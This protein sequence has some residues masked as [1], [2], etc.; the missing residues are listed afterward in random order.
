MHDFTQ[1]SI[2]RHIVRMS[3]PI[4]AGMLF[5]TLYY[6]V[7]LYFVA[8]LGGDAVA[9]VSAAGNLQFIVMGVTQVLSVGTMVLISH[10]AGRKD[11]ADANLIFH[12]SL[13]MAGI[14]IIGTLIFG[15][16][17]SGVYVG[18][19]AASPGVAEAA[20]QYLLGFLPA[21]AL[22]FGIVTMG[23]ALR[24]TG[25]A[26]PTMMVQMFSVLLNAILAPVLIAGVGTGKPLGVFGAGL[27]S[28]IAT[29]VAVLMM[30]WYFLKL[31]HFV[32]FDRKQM[33]FH[34]E[35]WKRILRVGIPAGGEFALM[36]AYMAVIYVIIRD[37]GA[38]AQAGFGLGGRVMQAMFIPAMS[39]AFAAAPIAGQNIGAGNVERAR[40]T[41]AS[42]V[43]IE[44]GVMI[45]LTLLAQSQGDAMVGFF[46]Q[47]QALIDVGAGFLGIIS[48]N[49][50]AQG[51]I[52]TA[53][54]MFQALGNTMPAMVSS[55]TR[56]VT[57]AIPAWYM[58][59][60]PG[61][62][63]KHVWYLSVATVSLQMFVSL[64]LL[65][66]EW[67]KKAASLPAVAPAPAAA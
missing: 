28:T 10:A 29:F 49:F 33:K 31:E 60:R 43:L 7:D 66:R 67:R 58:H 55:A 22:Q 54:G 15:A 34:L 14:C 2:P 1:G 38:S 21:L 47:D 13:L 53:S 61:F 45:V 4:F 59:L 16:T 12:Q 57:F 8:K 39:V 24:G 9:G 20:R 17:L 51:I 6:L 64:A 26:K 19:L 41:F 35:A 32:G 11:A 27:A 63:L 62:Q 46:T 36:F 42:A 48:F 18:T 5:S 3:V 52:F 44:S 37:I 23:A 65:A 25:V 50:V 30:L 56:L 40:K